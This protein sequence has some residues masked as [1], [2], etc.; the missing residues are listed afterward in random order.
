MSER[1]SRVADDVS[2]AGRPVAD[3]PLRAERGL[4]CDW[5]REGESIPTVFKGTQ[6][7]PLI[8]GKRNIDAGLRAV[9]AV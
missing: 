6:K 2:A 8:R 3:T 9:T 7:I 4:S 5:C 1:D